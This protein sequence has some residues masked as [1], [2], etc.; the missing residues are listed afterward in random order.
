MPSLKCGVL[1][2]HSIIIKK[3]YWEQLGCSVDWEP[4]L[5]LGVPGFKSDLRL[6]DLA[7][8]PW[9]GYLIT[10]AYPYH[11]S[12]L[13]PMHSIASKMEGKGLKK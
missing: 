7:V 10:I 8:W 2:K 1:N 13:E 9:A 4:G 11:S 3:I 6:C 12:A 5:E